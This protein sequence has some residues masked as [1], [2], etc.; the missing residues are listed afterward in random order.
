MLENS[1]FLAYIKLLQQIQFYSHF[2][3]GEVHQSKKIPTTK[4]C[5]PSECTQN[6]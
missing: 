1:N 6:C 4:V 2:L 3:T 5:I